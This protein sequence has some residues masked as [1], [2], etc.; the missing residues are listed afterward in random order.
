MLF[1]ANTG[2][3]FLTDELTRDRYLVDT[4][5]TLSIVPCN[6]KTTPSGPL[7]KG[8]GQ[9]IAQK[10]VQFQGKLFSSQFLQTAVAG[11]ILDIDI[12]RRS[13]VTVTPETSQLFF[14]CTTAAPSAPQSFLPSFDCSVLPPVS[15]STGT[16]SPP[17]ASPD[18]VFQLKPASFDCQGNQSI[19]DPSPP[20]FASFWP[21]PNA[22]NSS[23][24]ACRCQN[25]ASKISLYFEN[26]GCEANTKA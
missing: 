5:A 22:V 9:P 11:P 13:K 6:A 15:L 17:A 4:G 10:T 24:S 3:I 25:L 1:L 19:K 16:S 12:L 8:A 18:R 2:L 20:C 21:Q 14:A 26:W 7:F 23:F